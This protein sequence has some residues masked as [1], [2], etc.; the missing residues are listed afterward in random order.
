[1]TRPRT[2][3]ILAVAGAIVATGA[4]PGVLISALEVAAPNILWRV[5]TNQKILA[6]TFDDGPD[7][8]YTPALLEILSHHKVRATFFLAGRKARRFPAILDAIR[9]AGHAIGNHSDSLDRTLGLGLDEFEQ[10]L[11]RAEEALGLTDTSP[12]FF[13]P[14]GGFIS[15][16]Q[17]NVARS[18]GYTITLASGYA[19]DPY[20][21][22]V[23]YMVWQMKRSLSPGAILVFHDSG[24][25]RSKSLAAVDKLIPFTLE[26][27][28]QFVT[29]PEL[30]ANAAARP[31]PLPGRSAA[32]PLVP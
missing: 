9:S 29:L 23:R 8:I 32:P 26:Q 14:A 25:D 24:G 6:L 11:L 2:L 20:R 10:S 13:R 16:S 18:H 12:K 22:P 28:F 7:P 31:V 4:W 15:P 30:A 21:P 5:E 17:A 19:L 3:W 27:G 1:M